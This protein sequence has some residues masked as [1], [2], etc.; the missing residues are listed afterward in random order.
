MKA[1][2]L[3]CTC[4]RK[5]TSKESNL[6]TWMDEL[7]RLPSSESLS[8]SDLILLGSSL[9]TRLTLSADDMHNNTKV[10]KDKE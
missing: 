8:T 2:L 1:R 9:E 5:E 10:T 6:C 3:F 4:S 7:L